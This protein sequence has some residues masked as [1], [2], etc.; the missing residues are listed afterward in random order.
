MGTRYTEILGALVKRSVFAGIVGM[1]AGTASA[2]FLFLLDLVTR[3]RETN[4]QLIALL[5][6]CGLFVGWIYSRWGKSVE[7]GNNLI[8]EEIHDPKSVIPLRMAPLVLFGTI[9]THLFGGSAGREGTAVQMGGAISEQVARRCRLTAY[10]RRVLL[11]AGM[12]GGF[13]SVFGVPFAGGIFGLEVLRSGRVDLKA[14]V[15]CFA[16]SF[17][18]HFTC[19]AW[20]IQHSHYASPPIPPL[21]FAVLE[22]V[23]VAGALFGL[24]A[25]VFSRSMHATSRFFAR[26][27]PNAASR[28]FCGGVMVIG[29]YWALQTTRFAGLGIAEI[30]NSLTEIVPPFDFFWKMALTILTLGSGFK[31]GEVTPLLF[32]GATLGNSLGTILSAPSALL[33]A[34]GFVAV[35]SGAANTPWACVVMAMEI[36]GPRIGA[37]ALI[38]CMMSYFLSGAKGIY[39]AQRH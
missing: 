11:M 31:G 24:C 15:E 39:S 16:A 38:A 4:S 7:A 2:L 5:P 23:V 9:V 26:M 10:D 8:L 35:F 6:V 12:S 25:L 29:V 33:A 36:F 1:L 14:I 19:L 13:G 22:A 30:Q 21:D 34:V 18:G 3:W 27:I 37:F 28:A 32:I 20:G 17:V